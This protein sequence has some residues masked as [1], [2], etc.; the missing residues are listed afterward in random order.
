MEDPLSSSAENEASTSTTWSPTLFL[1]RCGLRLPYDFGSVV[2]ISE[3]SRVLSSSHTENESERENGPESEA[4][5]EIENGEVRREKSRRPIS[6]VGERDGFQGGSGETID[7]AD[8]RD[9]CILPLRVPKFKYSLFGLRRPHRP[10]LLPRH[11]RLALPS[12]EHLGT[13]RSTRMADFSGYCQQH[14]CLVG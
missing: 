5:K 1:D 8:M 9:P 11:P 7:S 14:Y 12:D 13:C 4:K 3:F 10:P 2:S 6:K